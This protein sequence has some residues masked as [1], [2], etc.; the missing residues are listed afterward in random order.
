MNNMSLQDKNQPSEF[1]KL[2]IAMFHSIASG[3]SKLKNIEKALFFESLKLRFSNKCDHDG[4]KTLISSGSEDIRSLYK[5]EQCQH[6]ISE[7][8]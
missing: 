7:F 4:K 8:D 3:K 2:E 6:T 5:C 1:S